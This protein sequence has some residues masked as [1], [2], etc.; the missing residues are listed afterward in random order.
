MQRPPPPHAAPAFA[1]FGSV[2]A[3]Y[4]RQAA[5]VARFGAMLVRSEAQR[6]RVP[7]LLLNSTRNLDAFHAVRGY[8]LSHATRPNPLLTVLDTSVAVLVALIV[9]T[10]FSLVVR[11]LFTPL[12]FDNV[13]SLWSV[14]VLAVCLVTL[15]AI[16]YYANCIQND[17]R[18]HTQALAH[19]QWEITK[20]WNNALNKL[21]KGD[22]TDA[23]IDWHEEQVR[24]LWGLRAHVQGLI[25]LFIHDPQFP[26]ILGASLGN[27]RWGMILLQLVVNTTFFFAFRSENT[28]NY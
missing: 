17:V 13:W 21:E 6:A 1:L 19:I 18:R 9:I 16:C 11:Q 4:R 5:I 12:D 7:Y 22:L 27:L 23:R 15:G 26:R 20:H 3:A 28:D 24:R 2:V 25:E 14:D 8:L 10:A